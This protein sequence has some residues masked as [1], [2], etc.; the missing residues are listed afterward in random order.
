MSESTADIINQLISALRGLRDESRDT[1]KVLGKGMEDGAK[2]FYRSTSHL[3]N[4]QRKLST[5]MTEEQKDIDNL[6]GSISDVSDA[7]NDSL[8]L[9]MGE[10]VPFIGVAV[11]A[12]KG[13][14]TTLTKVAQ[15]Y[16]QL[17]K[18]ADA[19]SAPLRKFQDQAFGIGK[20][21]AMSFEESD[22]FL[23]NIV[24]TVVASEDMKDTFISY[25]EMMKNAEGFANLGLS[26]EH[27]NENIDL[28]SRNMNLLATATLLSS[29][30]GED[31]NSTMNTLTK[32]IMT[33]G[34]SAEQAVEQYGLFRDSSEKTG[35][36][37]KDVK[38][39]LEG[40]VRGY[41]MLGMSAEFA[42]PALDAFAASLDK[43]GMGI[44]NAKDLAGS[45]TR[46]IGGMTESY[47]KAFITMSKGGMNFSGGVFGAS[48]EM[49]ARMMDAE[50][51]GDQSAMAK[52]VISAM[53][54]T[55]QSFTGDDIVTVQEARESPEL[56]KT[57]VMQQKLL[58][59]MYGLKGQDANR[60]L[61]ML[62][63][64]DT[65]RAAGD[66][67]AAEK[68]EE[69]IEQEVKGRNETKDIQ[70]RIAKNTQNNVM[71]TLLLNDNF[72]GMAKASRTVASG[73]GRG[74]EATIEG[75]ANATISMV[76]SFADDLSKM[77]NLKQGENPFEV[78]AEKGVGAVT[79]GVK[80]IIDGV[81]NLGD[82][83]KDAGNAFLTSVT[84]AASQI[85]QAF[86]SATGITVVQNQSGG[87][88]ATATPGGAYSPQVN[89]GTTTNGT[90]GQP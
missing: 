38:D 45:L 88:T 19:M 21:F 12:F 75:G 11:S 42:K 86:S 73:L 43:S 46:S 5:F 24:E 53:K 81:G 1:S 41:E 49:Q 74:A 77:M 27:M 28:G 30:A 40:A 68:L 58:G 14:Q 78:M 48:I 23:S 25:P 57:F 26:I 44:K 82:N 61:E 90:G 69:M 64:L 18:D 60:T 65:A 31:L 84:N 2:E 79:D 85:Q 67:E 13:L 36:S 76:D 10:S 70:E 7:I 71:A 37:M 56:Q 83:V 47:E 66:T 3:V 8:I 63:D 52:E 32:S 29:A 50:K 62:S 33:Q 17:I 89:P 20:G 15:G 35:L 87:F 9:K 55:L 6:V 54:G 72:R 4:A 51:T 16:N 80:D 59:E 34:L 22:K 39:A